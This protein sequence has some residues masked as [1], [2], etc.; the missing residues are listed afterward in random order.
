MKIA[1]KKNTV[2]IIK[3]FVFLGPI[4]NLIS[5][6]GINSFRLFYIISAIGIPILLMSNSTRKYKNEI[7]SNF[8]ISLPFFVYACLSILWSDAPIDSSTSA[9]S[10]IPLVRLFLLYSLYLFSLLSSFFILKNFSREETIIL[11][12]IYLKGYLISLFMGYLF[13]IG[14]GVGILSMESI[15]KFQV[16]TDTAYGILRFSPGS[17][18][19][20]Y[21]N[22]SGFVAC[23]L[24][25]IILNGQFFLSMAGEEFTKK[26]FYIF[27]NKNELSII[28]IF[29]IV[30]FFLTFTRT[31]Y[32]SILIGLLYSMSRV[33]NI[34]KLFRNIIFVSV[35]F[36]IIL[37]AGA[38]FIDIGGILSVGFEQIFSGE[39][40]AGER[41]GLWST[42]YEEFL[43][44]PIWGIGYGTTSFNLHNNYLQI[45]F[46]LGIVG[47]FLCILAISPTVKGIYLAFTNDSNSPVKY[48]TI[49]ALINVLIFGSSNHSLNH[50]LTWLSIMFIKKANELTK[51]N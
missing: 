9:V 44:N 15:E 51:I 33:K 22:V 25:F 17:Y 43:R 12:K 16:I 45:F 2:L 21:G 20:E 27:Y 40:S 23:L 48:F 46:E 35:F 8:L 29:V 37:V 11:I 47:T 49:L 30:A 26:N 31:V 13:Q 34:K 7:I 3:L 42:Y 18:A 19:N 39:G 32:L 4:G 6:P 36:I 5:L 41:Y 14:Y 24:I 1:D 28:L 50:H 10:D 38:K